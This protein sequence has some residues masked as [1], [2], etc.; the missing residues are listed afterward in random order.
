MI[1]S[2]SR[3]SDIPAFYSKWFMNRLRE[4]FVYT[5]NPMNRKQVS[6]IKLTPHDIECIVFWTKNPANLIPHLGEI[7]DLGYHYYFQ[8]TLTSY[9]K[10]VECNVPKKEHII[11]TFQ[12][13][14]KLIGSEKIIWRY[15]PI[16]FSDKYTFEYHAKWFRY[17]TQ[18]LE[19]FTQ[20]CTI[21][22]F[23][24]YKKCERNMKHLKPKNI[25]TGIEIDLEEPYPLPL[26]HKR[27]YAMAE[28]KKI[29]EV[30]KTKLAPYWKCFTL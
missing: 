20:K 29:L 6:N 5:V 13:L 12:K 27:D 14:S 21:S 17:I 16:F 18:Q 26:G 23:D 25:S 15:D 2:V 9:D 4:G 1:L 7:D 3:R 10:N 24:M 30:L 28:T 11:N 22:F 19:G 8:F